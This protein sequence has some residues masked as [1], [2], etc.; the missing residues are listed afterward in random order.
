VLT[1]LLFYVW[2]VGWFGLGFFV[3]VV[4]CL[5]RFSFLCSLIKKKKTQGLLSSTQQPEVCYVAQISIK[6][7]VAHARLKLPS[8]LTTPSILISPEAMWKQK[9]FTSDLAERVWV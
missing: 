6:C 5:F 4:V 7:C 8:W 2:L 9:L 3:V 1:L